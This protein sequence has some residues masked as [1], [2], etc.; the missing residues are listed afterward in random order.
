MADE[1]GQA[2]FLQAI[3]VILEFVLDGRRGSVEPKETL[4]IIIDRVREML[5]DAVV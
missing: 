2:P 1:T 4:D 3:E 5:D